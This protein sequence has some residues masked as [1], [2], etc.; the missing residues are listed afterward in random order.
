MHIKLHTRFFVFI[1]L[2]FVIL[3]YFQNFQMNRVLYNQYLYIQR[4]SIYLL[5]K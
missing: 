3:V 4:H 5:D 1:V 2:Y